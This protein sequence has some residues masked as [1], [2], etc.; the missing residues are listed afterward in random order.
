[1]PFGGLLTVGL[2]AA[3]SS[4]ASAEINSHQQSKAVKAQENATNQAIGNL[5]PFQE[6][7][8]Q[9]YQTLGGLMGLGG[10]GGQASPM[11]RLPGGPMANDTQKGALTDPNVQPNAAYGGAGQ[12][13]GNLTQSQRAQ[14][15][16]A[17]TSYSTPVQHGSSVQG[18]PSLR[19]QGPNGQIYVVPADQASTA[20]QN[21]GKVLGPV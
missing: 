20:Q 2:I 13:V 4:I 10:G 7:G 16:S 19:V 12:W 14:N 18:M 15:P 1:M 5:K 11:T 3:G 6:T 8:T 9:A 21:G 17:T